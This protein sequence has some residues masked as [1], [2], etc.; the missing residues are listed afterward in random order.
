[1]LISAL[2]FLGVQNLDHDA[3]WTQKE[4][5]RPTSALGEKTFHT[6]G[7]FLLHNVGT[8]DGIVM[9]GQEHYGPN[10]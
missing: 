4:S 8:G 5:L 1:M 9:A 2:V 3:H 7:D 6:F 10:I